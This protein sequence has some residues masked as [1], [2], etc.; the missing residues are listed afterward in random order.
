V[1]H[2]CNSSYSGDRDLEDRGSKPRTGQTV[3]E[4]LSQNIH[5]RKRAGGV[6]QGVDPEFNTQYRKK[7]KAEAAFIIFTFS[8]I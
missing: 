6:S 8:N 7:K 3:R 4:T 2:T 1:A 5:H